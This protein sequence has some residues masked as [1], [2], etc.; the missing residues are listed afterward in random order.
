MKIKGWKPG[1]SLLVIKL[2]LAVGKGLFSAQNSTSNI[3]FYDIWEYNPITDSWSQKADLPDFL[4]RN[5][6]VAVGINNKGYVG[7]GCDINQTINRQKFWEYDPALDSWTV[8]AN[9]PSVYTTDAGAFALN[10]NLYVV[11]GVR[12]SPVGLTSQFYKYDPVADT[13][14]Q[15]PNFN[16]GSIAGEF[17]VSTG[18]TAFAG[19]GY[20]GNIVTRTDLWEFPVTTG[21]NEN[22]FQ[23]NNNV[24][25]YPD[26]V[27]ENISIGSQKEF[28]FLKYMILNGNRVLQ[29]ESRIKKYKRPAS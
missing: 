14:T 21:L 26:P 6:S 5:M 22:N 29:D 9:F 15:L 23:T 24:T 8:K 28:L 1:P 18:T 4:G 12:L 25:I 19:T 27:K 10:S 2:M 13:W 7:L 17:A 11:G 16:G 20:N 3:A